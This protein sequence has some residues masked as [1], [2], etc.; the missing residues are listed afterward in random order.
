MR[1]C[2]SILFVA[3][4]ARAAS[5][6]AVTVSVTALSPALTIPQNYV[7]FT[8]DWWPPAQE[9]FGTSTVNLINFSHPR[10]LGFARAL[11]PTT[12]R[13]GGSLDN[14]IKYLVGS[15]PRASCEAPVTFRGQVFPN[16]CLN[17]SRFSEVLDF[18]RGGLAAGS[19]LVFGLQLDLGEGGN[20]PWNSTNVIDFLNAVSA[21][22]NT[23]ALEA[24]EVGEETT[25]DPTRTDGWSAFT[26]AYSGVRASIDALWPSPSR[27]LLLGPCT[28]M[29]EN[30]PPFAWATSFVSNVSVDAYVMHS[31]N[32]DGGG[33]WTRPGFLAQTASQAAGLRGML[34]SA[35]AAKGTDPLPL[36]C[37]ECG[38]HNGGGI[39][40]VTDRAISSFWYTDALNVLPLLGVTR[41]N[42]QT[43]SGASYS[44]LA[45]DI[46]TP[47]PDYFAA[48]AFTTLMGKRIL[49]ARS[50]VNV[51]SSL[52][53]YA[54][55]AAEGG[56]AITVAFVN[57][58]ATESFA[59]SLAG[60]LGTKSTFIFA[61]TNGD[62]LADTLTLNGVELR[63]DGDAPAPLIGVVGDAT[64][65]TEIS[66]FTFGYIVF[67]NASSTACDA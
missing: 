57:V 34:D 55:C 45:N 66:S 10:L 47:R 62:P 40:N 29:G 39:P 9:G 15:M 4:A 23:D 59:L 64:A 17:M 65:P 5:A 42:R 37:G 43:L 12:L 61:P 41:F 56:G 53:V 16:L 33:A 49:R 28:G 8:L 26:S 44:L 46:F 50:D 31:Y 35:A 21:L 19:T 25:P 3:A 2:A 63:P 38:P 14:V 7:G 54:A 51:S 24:F 48:L 36:W 1:R 11:G 22:P 27:P 58:N 32:N 30:S 18:V 52:H 6:T 20:G 60:A 67:H 13:I